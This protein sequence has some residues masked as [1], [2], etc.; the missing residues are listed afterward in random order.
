MTNGSLT[1][2]V[3]RVCW[4][5]FQRVRGIWWIW[6]VERVYGAKKNLSGV[7]GEKTV[8][9]MKLLDNLDV[10]RLLEKNNTKL[11]F[12]LTPNN[13]TIIRES[14]ARDSAKIYNSSVSKS[15]QQ[16]DFHICQY[17]ILTINISKYN[18]EVI[19]L[20]VYI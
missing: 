13:T 5:I 3:K 12:F 19:L 17:T 10:I 18:N 9:I 20:Y 16:I 15:L 4:C 8:F 7:Y 2:L 14:G 6:K 1:P 11:S